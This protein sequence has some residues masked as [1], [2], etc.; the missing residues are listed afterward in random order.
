MVAGA[1]DITPVLGRQLSG[2]RQHLVVF[3][4]VAA[5]QKVESDRAPRAA[6]ARGDGAIARQMAERRQ[7]FVFFLDT[8]GQL[9]RS[10]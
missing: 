8:H 3:R 2:R 5:G 9:V 1:G 7:Q 4:A 10:G 6:L